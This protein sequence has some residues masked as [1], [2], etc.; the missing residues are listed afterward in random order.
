MSQ[1]DTLNVELTSTF[2]TLTFEPIIFTNYNLLERSLII[3]NVLSFRKN[4][5]SM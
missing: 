3:F 5:Q 2:F 1:I 4:D